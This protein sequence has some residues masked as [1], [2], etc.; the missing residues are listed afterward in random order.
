[1]D[2]QQ[3][4]KQI[5]QIDEEPPFHLWNPDFCGDMD[6][7]IKSD[8]T[9]WYMGSPIGRIQLV[10]LFARVLVLENGEYEVLGSS[11]TQRTDCLVISATNGD[12]SALIAEDKFREDLYFRLNTIELEVPPL[13]DRRADI[14][15]LA[16]FFIQHFCH[17]YQQQLIEL[18]RDAQQALSDYQWPGNIRELSHLIERAVLLS[19]K[20]YIDS[21]DLQLSTTKASTELSLMPLKDAEILLIKQALKQTN[22]HIPSAAKLLGLTKSS[23]YRRIEKYEQHAELSLSALLS[24]LLSTK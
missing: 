12:F 24:D 3:L 16:N 18:S 17:K 4:S 22:N 11:R 20:T 8:G 23:M 6:L 14:I 19:N 21:N 10:K 1:M 5:D 15:P 2:L 9:W 13:R 7:T